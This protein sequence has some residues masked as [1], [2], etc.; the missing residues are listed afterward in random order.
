MWRGQEAAMR[1]IFGVIVA[2]FLAPVA[3]LAI[4]QPDPTKSEYLLSTGAGFG[5]EMGSGAYYGMIFAVHK[6]LPGTVY[7]IAVFDNPEVPGSPLHA[8][9]VVQADAN[10]IKLRSPVVHVIRNNTRY[11]VLL[12]L[13]TDSD[14]KNLLTKHSQ[15]VLFSVPKQLVSQ[16]AAQYALSVR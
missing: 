2:S 8:E 3:A 13:Y 14:H 4:S 10:E 6:P 16:L 7:V 1:F 5:L 12:T 11:N 15:E 9:I